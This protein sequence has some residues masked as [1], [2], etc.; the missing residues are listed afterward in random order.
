MN[1]INAAA[2]NNLFKAAREARST[3]LVVWQEGS[4]PQEWWFRGKPCLIET[5]SATKS[6]VNLIVGRAVTLGLIESAETPVHEFFPEWRQGQKKQI[7]LAHLMSHTSGLQDERTTVSEIYPSPDFV[8]LALAAE[9]EDAPGT[10]FKY[11][12]KATNLLA[13]V[14]AKATGK[15]MQRFAADA[16]FHPLEVEFDWMR[17]EAGNPHGMA[18][19]KL[20]PRDLM[21]FGQLML[22]RGRWDGAQLIAEDWIDRSLQPTL[23]LMK[24]CGWLWWLKPKMESIEV[25]EHHVAELE[26]AG[27]LSVDVERYRGLIG[28]Y[29]TLD[30]FWSAWETQLDERFNQ[31]NGRFSWYD[32]KITGLEHF[33]A[34]EF[35]GQCLVAVPEHRLV[36]VR[37]MEWFDG[38]KDGNYDFSEFHD[39]VTAL[40]ATI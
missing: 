15:P 3:A 20:Y 5:M 29:K 30:D 24:R 12:N 23:P 7:T 26:A 32:A 38:A 28:A 17:D 35:L 6:V 33:S 39:L 40:V 16:L 21:K 9:L 2:L 1:P 25:T 13:G 37:M 4:P 36:A 22:Q 19:L 18:G 27:A 31:F 11:S 8:K 10:R 14:I 34:Q